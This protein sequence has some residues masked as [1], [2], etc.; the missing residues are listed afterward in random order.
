MRRRNMSN[1]VQMR[2]PA[3]L[4]L[5]AT[6]FAACDDSPTEQELAPTPTQLQIVSGDQQAAA[7]GRELPNPLVVRVMNASGQAVGN[8][9]VN[10]R[11]TAGGGTLFAGTSLTNPLGVAQERWTLGP[12]VGPQTVEARAI[13]A[14]TGEK[15]LYAIFE[16]TAVEPS[17][18]V[19]GVSISPSSANLR[20]GR[21]L[22]LT[23]AAR[24]AEGDT[25]TGRTFTWAS[26]DSDVATVTSAGR[27]TARSSGS[28]TIT[29]SV[30]GRTGSATINVTGS[31]DTT[32]PAKPETPT[33]QTAPLSADSFTVTAT[34]NQVAEAV[35]YV[36]VG[37]S[38]SGA[39]SHQ[40]DGTSTS[41]TF[42]ARLLNGA[43][44]YWFCVAALDDAGN[45]S[46]VAC[47][48]YSPPDSGGGSGTVEEVTVAPSTATI[49]LGATSQLTASVLDS[50]GNILSG[51]TVTWSSSNTAVATVSSGGVVTA[52]GVGSASITARVD[53][54]SSSASITVQAEGDPTVAS[55]TVSPSSASVSVGGSR[56]LT[57]TA[58]DA[59]GNAIPGKDFT[60]STS[61]N[62][63]AAVSLLGL[64]TGQAAGTV[65]VTAAVDGESG[66]VSISVT[67]A[68][69]G[70][71]LSP[72]S[73]DRILFDFRQSLQNATS[74]QQALDLVSVERSGP[75]AFS[76]NV[77]GQGTKAL[78][79][80]WRRAGSCTDA[81]ALVVIRFPT[82]NLPRR[83][84]M[85]WKQHMGR[86][87]TGGGIGNVSQFSVT[88]D[89]C[90][91]AGRKMALMLRD[92]SDGGAEDRIEYLWPGPDPALPT[93]TID[94]RSNRWIGNTG[95]RWE[96][97][98]HV[99]ETF[100]HTL[101]YQAE[102][103]EGA[104][105]G[106][107]RLW[108][109]GQLVIERTDAD[110]GSQAFSRF[111]LPTTMRAPEFDQSEYFWDLVGWEPQ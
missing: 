86:T 32:P 99:G 89:A 66:S 16:A 111:E 34:W 10:F 64:V 105:D 27:V 21:S 43:G 106:I 57:A 94:S 28:A 8:Q 19:V 108:I 93:I 109:N 40:G 65:T 11:V 81:A 12:E 13:D 6:L 71:S 58:W 60:W 4:F 25:I 63:V 44:G 30:G 107:I 22:Q 103:S 23:A 83:A 17:E 73:G 2:R 70:G 74:E 26:S 59:D 18:L 78:R 80:D 48:R 97:Q 72:Q 77:D 84:F 68:S 110:I 51:K 1:R 36:W 102:S 41:T 35:N 98:Q 85:Q 37:G 52:Q 61:N 9:I 95:V 20:A 88:N 3:A 15:L 54:E 50:L 29:A 46:E 33:I 101:Y 69:G 45:A 96:P 62:S 91:N 7:A 55:V 42:K 82:S 75:W 104:N 79:V 39:F 24:N 90:G 100:S 47:N 92:V 87:S 67:G 56:Q 53:G 14:A 5:V 38:N 76:A 49:A 31:S